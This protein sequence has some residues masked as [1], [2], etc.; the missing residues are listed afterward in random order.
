MTH[1]NDDNGRGPLHGLRVIDMSMVLAGPN[2]ARYLADFG[3]DVIKVERPDGGD[4]LRNLA[5]RDPRDGEGLWWK[6]VNRN[7][8]TVA[9]DLKS[10]ADVEVLRSLV[11]DA[12]V[13]I[14]NFRPG[15]LERLG[16]GPD[17]LHSLNPALVITRVTG[18]G[19]TGP[20]RSRAGFATIAESMSGLAAISGEEGGQPLLPAIALTDEVT[21]VVA[22]FATM[23]ALRSG[24]GQVVDVSLLESLFQLMGP[25]I[26]LYELT[27]QMQPR[28]G[29]G[30]PYSVP[31]GTYLCS[32][33]KWIGVSTSSDSVAAR[34]LK[35]LG[36]GDDPRFTTFAARMEHRDA[37]E[38][39]MTDWCAHRTQADVIEAFTAAEAAIGP[40][41][42]MADIAVDPHYAA[43]DAIVDVEGTPMQG[44]IAK[45]SATPGALR[46]QGR[47]LDSDGDDIRANGWGDDR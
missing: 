26:S 1:T 19:Q 37:L 9:L 10:E 45:L 2:C 8:R 36:V 23:V 39:V 5:W 28:L 12:D 47:A 13:L 20:Y 33:G 32:D 25:L 4:S 29:S 30:L 40:V 11:R 17:V 44:L 43:R 7:K 27:G 6:L 31:R 14:E 15:T 46:W 41:M 38:E 3:A 35:L 24:V 22:A 34:V 18:F 21:G 42:S 16:L